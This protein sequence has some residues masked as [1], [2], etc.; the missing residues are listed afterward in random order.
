M[1]VRRVRSVA[2]LAGCWELED[3][4]RAGREGWPPRAWPFGGLLLL[5]LLPLLLSALGLDSLVVLLLLAVLA[6]VFA[7]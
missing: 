2:A 6:A 1:V 4:L 5:V 7:A 3:V